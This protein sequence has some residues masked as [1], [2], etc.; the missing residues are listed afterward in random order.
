MHSVLLLAATVGLADPVAVPYDFAHVPPIGFFSR[1]WD[2]PG[3]GTVERVTY[4]LKVPY[5]VTVSIRITD[6]TDQVF[7]SR[8]PS[9]YE[10]WLPREKALDGQWAL[11]FGGAK[12]G[13]L[14]HPIKNFQVIVHDCKDKTANGEILVRNVRF[15]ERSTDAPTLKIDADISRAEPPKTMTVAL[16]ADGGAFAGGVFAARW[17]D[18]DGNRLDERKVDCP[19]VA[20]GGVWRTELPY[21]ARPDGKNAIFCQV[22]LRYG[23]ETLRREGPAW[24]APV[25]VALQS[26]PRPNLPW[27]TGIYLHRWGF[28]PKSFAQMERLV[29]SAN[30][31]GLRWLREQMVW[32]YIAP[33][34]DE[35]DFAN[36]DRIMRICETNGMSVCML[37]SSLDR[38]DRTADPDYPERYCA[39][40]R[41]AVRR[42]RGRVASWEICNEPN[43]PW[44]MKPEWKANYRR[45]LPMATKVVHEEDPSART[46]GCSASGLG[47][48]FV[49]SLADETFD[50]VSVHPYRRFVDDREFLADLEDLYL[51][52]RG[53][54]VWM[55][56]IGWDSFPGYAR[57]KSPDHL[58]ELHE[59]ASLIARAYMTAA[60]GRGVKAVFGYDYV[61]DGVLAAGYEYHMGVVCSD[62]SP[63]PAYRALAKVCRTFDVGTPSMMVGADGL[64]VF[65]MGDKCAVWVHGY[66]PRRISVAGRVRTTN[67]MDEPVE[68][69]RVDG[70]S[71]FFADSRHPLFFDGEV[72]PTLER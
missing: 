36:Y 8:A 68:P 48:G 39:A 9:G 16:K 11:H 13:V 24:T 72:S 62:L 30:R 23:T 43:L 41:Q 31:A 22:A 3:S 5:R 70:R 47:L 34:G 2:Y 56:E 32:R 59:Y 44:P 17:Y 46:V 53:R 63:K 33:K 69:E 7:Q 37:F 61:D 6:A 58:V 66:E 14:H 26:E 35:A 4:D 29:A 51:A 25:V 45:L 15:V 42:Y 49:K 28:A 54:A 57:K 40:L 20:S 19:A 1:T 60:A 12:D 38:E 10:T 18:W 65:R 21:A 52:S 50:D 71:F 55:T 64:T 27:G 67:L